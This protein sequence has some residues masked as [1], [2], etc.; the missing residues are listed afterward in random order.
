VFGL[1]RAGRNREVDD[2]GALAQ[3]G[4][5][6]ARAN[7]MMIVA[8][9]K[10]WWVPYSIQG[11]PGAAVDRVALR[12]PGRDRGIRYAGHRLPLGPVLDLGLEVPDTRIPDTT[13]ECPQ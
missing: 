1:G 11:W 12:L 5:D 13:W 8:I 3:R 7:I 6:G 2:R 10:A 9:G 4:P